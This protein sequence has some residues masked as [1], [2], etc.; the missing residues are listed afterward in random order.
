MENYGFGP[1]SDDEQFVFGS[2]RPCYPCRSARQ[3]DIEDWISFV[4]ERG[5]KRVCCLLEQDQ[6]AYYEED[7][8]DAYRK[9]F[10]GMN[11]CWAPVRDFHLVDKATLKDRV[12]PFLMDSESSR[13]RVVVHC[14]GG[15]GRTGQVLS[16]WL[17]YRHGL[18][19]EEAL[20]TV[21]KTGR[22]P[23]EA[24]DRGNA[25][26]EDLHALLLEC[27]NARH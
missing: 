19:I 12:L 11:V 18:P 10:G 26:T 6:L 9:R 17:V 24:V 16:A 21:R 3:A 2:Q 14:S 4:E 1:A 25:S 22:N 8:L 23:C 5:I 13:E 15:N 7:L 20:S 27:Q